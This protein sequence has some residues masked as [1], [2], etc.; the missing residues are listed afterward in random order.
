MPGHLGWLR[1]SGPVR[2]S[3]PGLPFLL[4]A[5]QLFLA[6]PQ[7]PPQNKV[8]TFS[9]FCPHVYVKTSLKSSTPAPNV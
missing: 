4:S 1:S 9:C 5:A 6:P 3:A 8:A 7:S 2:P